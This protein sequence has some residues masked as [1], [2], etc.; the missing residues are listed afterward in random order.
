M[1]VLVK[2]LI[3]MYS[4][5]LVVPAWSETR[6]EESLVVSIA[7]PDYWCP[8]ACDLSGSRSGFT[9]DIVRFALESGGHRVVYQNLP[10]DRALFEARRGR[11][12]A[13]LPTFR[14]EAPDVIFPSQAVSLTEYCFYVSEDEPWR[15]DGL[16]SLKNRQ[17]VATS[18][19]SYG[20][21]MDAYISEN[22]DK[23]VTL[24]QGNGVSGRLRELVRRKRFDALLDDRLL[25][26]FSQD[27]TGLSNAGCLVERH[28]GY[29]ALSPE[30]PDRSNTIARA[31]DGG[32]KDMRED[33]QLCEILE[34]YGL[35]LGG[36]GTGR[37]FGCSP[38]SD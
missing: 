30:N 6:A 33:G 11:I 31:F 13:V 18:G 12:D 7:A 35:G 4:T 2:T 27:S 17:F 26:E 29:L 16:D 3:G 9:V 32:I 25:F 1:G 10:Y 14:E 37:L 22:L 24:I 28:D 34:D 23:R 19:Y 15:Y 8:Y 38:V 21:D 5:L 36:T 20:N